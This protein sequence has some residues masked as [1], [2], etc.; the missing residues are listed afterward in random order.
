MLKKFQ[1]LCAVRPG[2]IVLGKVLSQA[3][4]ATKIHLPRAKSRGSESRGCV[5]G[6]V[7]HGVCGELPAAG[8]ALPRARSTA[9]PVPPSSCTGCLAAGKC[10][11]PSAGASKIHGSMI[12]VAPACVGEKD[13]LANAVCLDFFFF[14][15]QV[16]QWVPLAVAVPCRCVIWDIQ[17]C[18]G[19][20]ASSRILQ[21]PI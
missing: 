8:T 16:V 4:D 9:Q 13:F 20:W 12:N 3:A 7:T 10:W 1:Y 11:A 5:W 18:H 17:V 21:G 19:C 6:C 15:K 14:P 2:L